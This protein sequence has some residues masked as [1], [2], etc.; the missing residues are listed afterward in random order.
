MITLC[1]LQL[2][3]I[4]QLIDCKLRFHVHVR[5]SIDVKVRYL[6]FSC[7]SPLHHGWFGHMTDPDVGLRLV[8]V[9]RRLLDLAYTYWSAHT[10]VL[11]H[12]FVAQLRLF[13]GLELFTK[14]GIV[15]WVVVPFRHGNGRSWEKSVHHLCLFFP[16]MRWSE[17]WRILTW[18]LHVA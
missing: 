6:R 10:Q 14:Q 9:Q 18:P 2:V 16:R 8:S 11:L 1:F 13:N 7:C 15:L 4:D 5:C 12:S 3:L 17:S